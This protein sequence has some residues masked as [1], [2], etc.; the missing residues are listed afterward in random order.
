MTQSVALPWDDRLPGCAL[1]P[2][3]GVWIGISGSPESTRGT[4]SHRAVGRCREL[5][6]DALEIA[7][8]HRVSITDGGAARVRR[9]ANDAQVRL[10]VHAPYYINLNSADPRVIGA[11]VERI[12]AAGRAASL[13]WARDVVLHLAFYHDDPPDAVGTRVAI[14]LGRA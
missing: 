6:I 3:G 7:W 13:V 4:G 11:S 9:A 2:P 8:V 12:V 1:D 5:E 10:S 14:G